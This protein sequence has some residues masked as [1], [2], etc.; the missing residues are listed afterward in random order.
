MVYNNHNINDLMLSYW[1]QAELPIECLTN[2]D[3]F[4][5]SKIIH[6]DNYNW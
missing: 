4:A 1:K 5:S 2:F 3:I 6:D